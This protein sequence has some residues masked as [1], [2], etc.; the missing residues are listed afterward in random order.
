MALGVKYRMSWIDELGSSTPY[1][2]DV[3]TEGYVGSLI[4]LNHS[5]GE[6]FTFQY[7]SDDWVQGFEGVFSFIVN[8]ANTAA[9]D[10]DFYDSFYKEFK[11]YFYINNV[12][13]HVGWIKPEN[14]TRQYLQNQLRYQVSFTDG[15]HDL[16]DVPYDGFFYSG[17]QTFLQLIKNALSFLGISELNFFVQCNLYEDVLMAST[18]NLFVS[19]KGSNRAFYSVEV[20]EPKSDKCYEVLEKCVKSFYCRLSQVDGYWKIT[21]GSEYNS[22]RIVYAYSNLAVVS[23]S[24]MNNR[25]IDISSL[26][27]PAGNQWELTKV[28]PI[29]ILR[30]IWRNKNAGESEVTNGDFSNGTT[31]WTNGSASEAWY[32][33]SVVSGKLRLQEDSNIGNPNTD[34]SFSSSTFNIAGTGAGDGRFTYKFE[35][36]IATLTYDFGSFETTPPYLSVFLTYPNG[37]VEETIFVMKAG[38][39]VYESPIFPV[40]QTG[41]HSLKIIYRPPS[42]YSPGDIFEVELLFDNIEIVQDATARTTFDTLYI[43]TSNA[44]GYLEEEE[45]VWFLDGAQLSDVGIIFKD[46]NLFSKSWTRYGK[47]PAENKT[48]VWQLAQQWLNDRRAFHDVLTVEVYDPTDTLDYG[49]IVQYNS[50]TYRFTDYSKN[51]STKIVSGT[52][53]QVQTG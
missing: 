29:K 40:T 28:P 37:A 6:A 33:F 13:K 14:T 23:A 53:Q 42:F 36:T 21:N 3:L 49:K 30:T 19:L 20:G 35:M 1:R 41:N 50:K 12:L 51:F 48:L 43:N 2:L 38:T 47:S 34:K 22:P 5:I 8:E 7:S 32:N 46:P 31:G 11:V 18:D 17:R 16:K 45:E 15:L 10:A 52:L 9:Y 27:S 24:S 4:E 25:Q 26:Y 39:A 44:E